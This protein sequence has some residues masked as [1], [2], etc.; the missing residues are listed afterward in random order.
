[1]PKAE[2][3]E[4]S[5]A[6]LAKPR[7]GRWARRALML[8][9]A[10]AIAIF[11]LPAVLT[12]KTAV[13]FGLKNLAGLD[14]LQVEVESVKAGWLSP[15]QINGLRLIDADGITLLTAKQVAT[16][17]GLL[18]WGLNQS[19]LGHILLDQLEVQLD[20]DD[21]SS[22][23]ERS[24]A[25]FLSPTETEDSEPEP[26][27]DQTVSYSGNIEIRDSKISIAQHGI[28]QWTMSIPK[29]Q[30]ALPEE[31]QIIGPVDLQLQFAGKTASNQ[32]H[33]GW[34]AAQVQQVAES[35]EPEFELRAKMQDLPLE[36]WQVLKQRFAFLPIEHLQGNVSC[37]L[38]G[39]AASVDDWQVSLTELRAEK[40]LLD[41]PEWVGEKPAKLNEFTGAA[42]CTLKDNFLVLRDSSLRCDFAQV[43]AQAKLPWPIMIPSLETPLVQGFELN[44]EGSVDL[45]K[46]VAAAESLIPV[47]DQTQ[48]TSGT[49]RFKVL[50]G[51]SP[52]NAP[53]AQVELNIEGLQ[54]IA[55]G[56]QLTWPE[57]L[58]VGLAAEM[59]PAGLR[60]DAS[61][62]ADFAN[63][64]ANGSLES[65]RLDAR[66]DLSSLE[67]KLSQFV[68]LPITTMQGQVTLGANWKLNSSTEIL[69]A[70]GSLQ[71]SEIRLGTATGKLL[72]EQAWQ[73]SF[74]TD[75]KIINGSL[76][77]M[78][79]A[80][81][82][83]QSAAERLVVTLQ[84][85]LWLSDAK[86]FGQ[87]PSPAAF[88]VDVHVDLEK[89]NRR[90]TVWLAEPTGVDLNGKLQLAASGRIDLE[91][92][93][94][95]SANWSGQPIQVI[96][97]QL[98]F[99]E[100]RVVGNFQGRFD[101][102]N[103]TRTI[104][105]SL[106]LTSSSVSLIAQDQAGADG[107]SRLGRAKFIVDLGRLLNNT[108]SGGSSLLT[109]TDTNVAS[110]QIT[111]TGLC[112]GELAWQVNS[113][114][115]GL[116]LRLD[117]KDVQIQSIDS[118]A[119]VPTLLWQEPTVATQLQGTWKAEENQVQLSQV[120]LQTPWLNYQGN[121][122]YSAGE[123]S[124]ASLNGTA[125][126]DAGQLSTKLIPYTGG[127]LL[128]AGKHT[129]PVSLSWTS[130]PEAASSLS[131]I[132][133]T[134][135]LGWEQ[136]RVAGITVGA[137][138]VPLKLEQGEFSSATEI[139]VSGGTLRWD[140]TGDLASENWVLHQKPMTVLEN[141][142]ITEEMCKGWLK[143]VA[144][145][146]AEATS[147][148]GRLSLEL[149]QAKFLPFEPAKQTV[150]GKLKV[151]NATVGPGVLSAGV[152]QLVRDVEA[153][154]KRQ[155]A[156]TVSGT[157]TIW[158]DMQPQE[159]D[160]QMVEGQITHRNIAVR[161]GDATVST[162]GTVH[163]SGPMQILTVM[164]IPDDWIEKSPWLA[165]LRGQS[166]QFPIVGTISN[167]QIDSSA[168]A[169]LGQATIQN[170][171]SGAIQQGINKGIEKLIG[172][173]GGTLGEIL[174]G[175]DP[176]ASQAPAQPATGL[177][178]IGQQILQGQGI[179]IPGL[180]GG[181]QPPNGS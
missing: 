80:D 152:I 129:S 30:V 12:T 117:G 136:A 170:A 85:P 143:Y 63:I 82:R 28:D 24:L 1:M 20:L 113:L 160:F 37:M 31:E 32:H 69:G 84:Q 116:N 93:E 91:H 104:V 34:I 33:Q 11:F 180:F 134:T 156:Q 114:A 47:R 38:A 43:N 106:E 178:G 108:N 103:L 140:L 36:L 112:E 164:P 95:L 101:S 130:V 45:P 150:A 8:T 48:L 46:L 6:D 169:Q 2:L 56:Q 17:K 62:V 165:G 51:P 148:D 121:S 26:S 99:A 50:H 171:A 168:I 173:S 127:Q 83:L 58:K 166:L 72:E 64:K 71:S 61:T 157:Q 67:R 92:V 81:A 146:L 128:M 111:A 87:T 162:Q 105:D 149:S 118:L 23:L 175:P 4:N 96:T 59:S 98:S 90:G 174:R 138:N 94:I 131:G 107:D 109:A 102:S 163:V 29:A 9:A 89:C 161:I 137:A 123:V 172:E 18:S 181:S 68:E 144:P 3:S 141:V 39:R 124:K 35:A 139:P 22:N 115:A 60:L 97:P 145:I 10:L 133:A 21:E 73:G 88:S 135:Q 177:R 142:E 120:T 154:R 55:G 125:V 126:Y 74:A 42:T 122:T 14:P 15:L 40:M 176:N 153:I 52:T 13:D 78:E 76:A 159:I 16:Q 147:V 167:P 5:Q 100:P 54:A 119:S 41:A 65:G 57:P 86:N 179:G 25:A 79:H 132:S 44:T 110:S 155:L 75:I 19:D 53:A 7:K 158:M 77:R 49:V 70:S 151:H 66:L 27:A